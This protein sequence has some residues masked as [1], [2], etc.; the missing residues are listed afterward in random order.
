MGKVKLYL[1]I[2]GFLQNINS[3]VVVLHTKVAISYLSAIDI[4]ICLHLS[5]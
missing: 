5:E 2:E 3:G 4:S 1:N